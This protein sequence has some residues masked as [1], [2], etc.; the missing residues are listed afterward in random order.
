VLPLLVGRARASMVADVLELVWGGAE[1]VVVTSTDL[2]HYLPHDMAVRI[3]RRTADLIVERD[4]EHLA[5][6]AACGAVAVRGVLEVAR[7]RDLPGRLVD[8]STSGDTAG[9][10]DRVVGYGAFAIA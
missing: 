6:D 3:D 8:L 5:S 2:S 9:D 4:H 10:R 7:R 1:T